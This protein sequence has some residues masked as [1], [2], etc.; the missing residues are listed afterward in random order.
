M[1]KLGQA[2]RLQNA[3]SY[4]KLFAV[5]SA[6]L[7]LGGLASAM[8]V[9]SADRNTVSKAGENQSYPCAVD[10]FYKGA[11]ICIN[12]AGYAVPAAD[13]AG[14]STVVGV[15]DENVDN[16]GGSA[17]TLNVRVKSGRRFSFVATGTL[18]QTDVG[19]TMY[20]VDDQTFNAD[21]Q[22]NAVV[23]GILTEFTSTTAGYIYIGH[24]ASSGGIG[25][26]T[27]AMLSLQGRNETGSTFEPGDICYVNGYD[28]TEDRFTLALAD[29]DSVGLAAMNLWTT[30]ESLA[31][32]T[33]GTF[34]KTYR[35]TAQATDTT[36]EGD[37]VYLSTTPG[38]WTYTSPQDGDPNGVTVVVGYVAVV[39]ATVGEV[40]INLM[41]GGL[42]QIGT[43]EIQDSAV[44]TA[45]VAALAIT[46]AKLA[47]ANEYISTSPTGNGLGYGTGAGGAV[48]QITNRSTG[49]TVNTLC[50]TITT[51]TT[52]LAAEGSA[53]F[54][55]TNSEVAIGDVVILSIQSGEDGGGTVLSVQDVANGSFTIRVH[56]GNATGGTA[57]TGAILINFAVIK[58]VSA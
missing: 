33:N 3:R 4:L 49:V 43:N 55:V 12:G 47:A 22:V 45:K 5:M 17:G 36:T 16:S 52:S 19:T 58:A 39:S 38:D 54:I 32:A 29:A 14:Y 10:I 6:L 50:G 11:M 1:R 34:H 53:D 42:E 21:Q 18:A 48:T 56:N 27:T 40:E 51:D 7:M 57:E 31:T 15:A 8:T 44:A 37:R 13:T 28:E 25:G 23:A 9:L 24:P 20:V 2:W 35:E 41:A 46:T 26:V 30:R